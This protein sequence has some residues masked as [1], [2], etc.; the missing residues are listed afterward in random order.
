VTQPPPRLRRPQS[1]WFR[2]GRPAA[3]IVLLVCGVAAGDAQRAGLTAAPQLARAYDAVFDARFD[4]LP[5]L[6]T[7]TCPPA[8]REACQLLEVIALWWQI[9][10]D[11]G[12]RA[13]DAAFEARADESIAA[14][15]AWTMR[16]PQRAEAWF[17][18]GGAYGARAQWRV[19]RGDRVAAARDGARI[20]EALERSLALDAD[21][22]DAYFGI[23]LYHY[24]AA[25]APA[26]AR[27]LRWLLFLP[28]GDKDA[29]MRE[30]LRARNGGQL[31]RS[32]A[33]YQLHVIYL[34]YEKQPERALELLRALRDRHPRNPHFP[35]RIAEVEDE[36]LHD[37]AASLRSWQT[38]LEGAR[39]GRI[40]EAQIA[41][42]QAR[43][44]IAL[45]LDRQFETDAALPH[46]RAIVMARPAAP[47]GA[48]SL[49][50]LRLGQALD[51]LGLRAEAVA[52][53]KNAAASVPPGDP[54]QVA[55]AAR[56]ALRSAP[57]TAVTT[58]YR[59]SLEG[60][61][62]LER[63]AHADAAR[64]LAEST[65]L[66][67]NDAVTRYR[68]AR[69][70]LA[71]GLVEEALIE[72]AEIHRRRDSTPESI[73]LLACVD[74]ARAQEQ[75]GATQLAIDLYRSA[76]TVFGGDQRLKDTARRALS[77]LTAL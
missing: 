62:A 31:L 5:A 38:L 7:E 75:K 72:F 54:F 76:L 26:A 16:E 17:Y 57:P 29:G 43:L 64:L 4:Q 18:L 56:A 70:L 19:L 53:Y 8:P 11:P 36:Y 28:G 1:P 41:E 30:M 27:M 23:G 48:L 6:L 24:Y 73:Y 55:D 77:R 10:L 67:P 33:D 34:W 32:E 69:L 42:T 3:V 21:L 20:K 58:A 22:Q 63:G 47:L 2:R 68:Q 60:W 12:D 39:A 45:Q 13:R 66:R 40:A 71:Q 74:A 35:Q 49:A 9:Q 50:H 37:P 59:L 52:A 61:R 14:I 46:L 44:G 15:E 51:R 65:A 25:V